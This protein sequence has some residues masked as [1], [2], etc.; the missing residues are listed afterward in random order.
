MRGARPPFLVLLATVGLVLLIACANV[1]NLILA[2]LAGR[3]RELAVRAA[4]GAGRS[5]L[6]RQLLTESTILALAGGVARAC[7]WPSRPAGSSRPSRPASRRA[8][9]R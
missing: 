8:P 2:R 7:C 4:L 9:P 5:R 1:A 3:E 6:L